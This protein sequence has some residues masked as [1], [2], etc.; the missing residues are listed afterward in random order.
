MGLKYIECYFKSR[1][2]ELLDINRGLQYFLFCYSDSFMYKIWWRTR[3]SHPSFLRCFASVDCTDIRIQEPN[4]FS[5]TFNLYKFN[6]PGISTL[7]G[8]VPCR[9]Y[10]ALQIFRKE[11]KKQLRRGEAF[12][13]DKGYPDDSC[14]I[15]A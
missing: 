8:S 12:I 7:F 9:K 14:M 13:G 11:L 5:N 6:G 2:R 3:T 4:I 10:T 15:T 1:S